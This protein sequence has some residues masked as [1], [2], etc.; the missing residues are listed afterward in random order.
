MLGCSDWLPCQVMNMQLLGCF[1]V[2][3]L[4][5]RVLW[6]VEGCM[7]LLRC[8]E[9]LP[10]HC[11][12]VA[13]VFWMV[14]RALISTWERGSARCVK[15][16]DLLPLIKIPPTKSPN[17]SHPSCHNWTSGLDTCCI[18]PTLFNDEELIIHSAVFKE[19]LWQLC[20]GDSYVI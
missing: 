19:F 8:S 4:I 6:G 12:V 9:W 13:I 7:L 2:V 10:R 17:P 5:S 16:F 18:S 11:Y 20:V 1:Q 3:T 15:N 14:A